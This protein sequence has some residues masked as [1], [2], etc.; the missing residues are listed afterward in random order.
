MASVMMELELESLSC[1]NAWLKRVLEVPTMNLSNG[2][3]GED[4]DYCMGLFHTYPALSN[5]LIHA[6]SDVGAPLFRLV[7]KSSM[8]VKPP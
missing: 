5:P 8:G 1:K 4:A 6:V 2:I 3:P 7:P